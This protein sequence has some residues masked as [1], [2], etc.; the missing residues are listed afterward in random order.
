LTP[1]T[2]AKVGHEYADQSFARSSIP[3]RFAALV[4]QL[5]RSN[6]RPRGASPSGPFRLTGL[7]LKQELLRA[8]RILKGE[9][10]ANLPVV[11]L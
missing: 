7:I 2:E 8:G 9:K 5:E 11:H 6:N 1:R 3:P 4:T 10:P